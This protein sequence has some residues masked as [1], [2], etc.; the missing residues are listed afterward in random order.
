MP[1]HAQVELIGHLG[2]D[3][4]MENSQVRQD[5]WYGKHCRYK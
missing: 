3:P 2:K 5:V 4:E 1:N